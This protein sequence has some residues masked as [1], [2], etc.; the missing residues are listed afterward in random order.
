M[1]VLA[2]RCCFDAG[3]GIAS[4]Q[5][6]Q[7]WRQASDQLLATEQAVT[8]SSSADGQ[9]Q[10]ALLAQLVSRCGTSRL[11]TLQEVGP[12]KLCLVSAAQLNLSHL[13]LLLNSAYVTGSQGCP[14][15]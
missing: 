8:P 9:C 5:G 15:A 11:L 7:P 2:A 6:G 4:Y 1:Q 10:T 3:C 14:A 13:N 12:S